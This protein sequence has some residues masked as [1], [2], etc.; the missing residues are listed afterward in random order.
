MV[1]SCTNQLVVATIT[2]QN[3]LCSA[4]RWVC[5]CVC[6]V[7]V[8]TFFHST[9][10]DCLT[11]RTPVGMHEV[12]HCIFMPPI[13]LLGTMRKA[14]QALSCPRRASRSLAGEGDPNGCTEKG[15]NHEPRGSH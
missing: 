10:S 13:S 2:Q 1:I 3:P 4:F 8:S 11:K 9:S 6:T 5:V 12:T 15:A 7:L 14:S